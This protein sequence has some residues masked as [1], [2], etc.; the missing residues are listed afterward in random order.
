MQISTVDEML[1]DFRLLDVR[2]NGYSPREI[3]KVFGGD[4]LEEALILVLFDAVVGNND[5]K[6]NMG[7][8]AV[9]KNSKTGALSFPPLFDFNLAHIESKNFFLHEVAMTL[10]EEGLDAKARVLLA[11][12]EEKLARMEIAGLDVE[13]QV[14]WREA[15]ACFLENH[16][17]LARFLS[18]GLKIF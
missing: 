6:Q 10:I 11:Y 14:R 15:R 13:G 4:F 7:N 5:R 3:S 9:L 12:W 2:V 8:L 17:E 16:K 1:L 18:T